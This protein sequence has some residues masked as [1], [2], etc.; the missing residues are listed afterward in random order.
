MARRAE[1]SAERPRTFYEAEQFLSGLD[2]GLTEDDRV[3]VSVPNPD[4]DN[5]FG[6]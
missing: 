1:N 3:G 6:L 4:L 5:P 2:L